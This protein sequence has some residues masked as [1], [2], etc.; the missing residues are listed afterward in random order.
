MLANVPPQ[1]QMFPQNPSI[2]GDQIFRLLQI[3]SAWLLLDSITKLARRGFCHSCDLLLPVGEVGPFLPR[4]IIQGVL[5][6]PMV[7]VSLQRNSI[8]V[9]GN[10]GMLSIG[11]LPAGIDSSALTWIPLRRYSSDVGGI[12]APADSPSEVRCC[13]PSKDFW[14]NNCTRCIL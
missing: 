3:Y 6:Q 5:S 4:L 7:V 2:Q 9:G 13:P 8:D 12:P 14:T 1:S 11:E 10:L